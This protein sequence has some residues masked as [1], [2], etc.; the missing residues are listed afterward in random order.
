VLPVAQPALPLAALPR[1]GTVS[2][3]TTSSR[4]TR[5]WNFFL[6]PGQCARRSRVQVANP[7]RVARP[8]GMKPV[9]GAPYMRARFYNPRMGRFLNADPSGFGGGS[10]WYR[11]AENNPIMLNDPSGEFI[12]LVVILGGAF[13][14]ALTSPHVANAP[15]PGD[16][17]YTNLGPGALGP[18]LLTGAVGASI[19]HVGFN[20]IGPMPGG[21]TSPMAQT[22]NVADM[23]SAVPQI[24]TERY[25]TVASLG[26][27]SG[28][29]V[30][31]G[32]GERGLTAAQASLA[33]PGD[34]V[35]GGNG[36][37]AE[38]NAVVTAWDNGL[39]PTVGAVS[40]PICPNCQAQL[41]LM[42]AEI[43]SP[44]TFEFPSLSPLAAPAGNGSKAL[45]GGLTT[46]PLSGNH[47]KPGG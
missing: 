30:L 1:A 22:S 23:A 8:A 27:S 42:G 41:T 7:R 44:T 2:G 33:G 26:T 32:S 31:A 16:P 6:P 13:V 35:A 45:A 4:K 20:G 15:G 24:V 37:H 29:N 17:T 10:N 38:I 39:T 18:T 34:I 46:Q 19:I 40:K 14:A 11:Y 43:T 5:V 47:G 12:P 28:E 25:Q 21:Y 3:R 9:S 36:I